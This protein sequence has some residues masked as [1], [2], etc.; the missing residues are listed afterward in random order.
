[1]TT[2]EREKVTVMLREEFEVLATD[3]TDIRNVDN[4]KMKIWLKDD[5]SCKATYHSVLRPLYQELKH[6]EH[7]LNKQW[8]TNGHSEYSSPL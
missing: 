6:M 3:D 1:M 7:L 2:P 4:S 5:I 8:I